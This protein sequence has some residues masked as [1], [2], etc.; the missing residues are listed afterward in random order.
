IK[1]LKKNKVIENI[2]KKGSK[3]LEE[4]KRLTENYLDIINL[5]GIPPMPFFTFPRDPEGKYKE[6]RVKFYT[7]CI[8]AG[9]FMQP[10]HHSY[11][12]YRHTDK[13]LSLVLNAV[14]DALKV[15]REV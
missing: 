12:C 14:S 5:S 8:R 11:I 7:E 1:F 13:D 9:V 2:W 6:R 4:L 15:I 3:L 10:Y